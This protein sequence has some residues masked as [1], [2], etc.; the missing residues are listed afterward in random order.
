VRNQKKGEITYGYSRDHR[1]DLKQ[2]ILDLMCSGDGDIPLRGDGNESDSAMFATLLADFKRQ[3]Q[4]D[5][6]FVAD[7]ALYTEICNKCFI[8]VGCRVPGTLT[9]AKT[10]L[11]NMPEE[12]FNDSVISGYR[13]APCC[14]EYGGVRQRWLV[15]ESQA[16]K[17]LTSNSWKNVWL[18]TYQKPNPNFGCCLNKNLLAQS[19][20]LIAAERLSHKLLHQLAD[21]QVK[22]VRNILNVVDQVKMLA[23]PLPSWCFTWTKG[24]CAVEIKRFILAT[25][26]IDTKE[27]SDDDAL[28]EYKAQQSTERGFRFLK[29]PL[30][31]LQ[32]SSS[33]QL[34][35]SRH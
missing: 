21:I 25:N 26:V 11:E 16:R 17:M 4:I 5:A 2:F 34:S 8:C 33:T 19:Y 15:V 22:E 23:P 31:L 6:L 29:D 14:S 3:W 35:E 18:N 20:A 32:V 1:P 12:A 13:I 30:F 10:L 27:L 28:R 24:N 7:A 9:A